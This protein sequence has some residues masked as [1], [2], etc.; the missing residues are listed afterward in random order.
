ME[1]IILDRE[2]LGSLCASGKGVGWTNAQLYALGITFPLKTGWPNALYGK[3][4]TAVEYAYLQSLGSL[5]A[6][7]LKKYRKEG[8]KV[9]RIFPKEQ[10]FMADYMI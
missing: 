1:N 8:N 2:T 7:A 6:K 9:M 4:I 5:D 10:E 3:T